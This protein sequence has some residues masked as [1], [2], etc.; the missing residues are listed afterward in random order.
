MLSVSR[1]MAV[2]FAAELINTR[3]FIGFIG[4]NDNPEALLFSPCID[5]G[6]RL[7][8]DAWGQGLAAEG[9]QAVLKF[10]FLTVKLSELVSMTPVL[11]KVS[12]RI[13]QKIGI[14]KESTNF[15]H[16]SVQS[17]HELEEHV[18]YSLN[19]LEYLSMID[20]R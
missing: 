4:I 14:I 3:E 11:N 9:A 12:E 17:G 18:L 13:M 2:F 1:L 15:M 8:Y 20:Q 16:P 19:R 10:A 7:K 5:I 6:W